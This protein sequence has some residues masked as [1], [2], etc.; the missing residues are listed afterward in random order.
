MIE[1]F[2]VCSRVDQE[3]ARPVHSAPVGQ[4]QEE[5]DAK[6]SRIDR[7][8][9]LPKVPRLLIL[10]ILLILCRRHPAQVKNDW[11]CL[12]GQV[13]R[14][15]CRRQVVLGRVL[16]HCHSEVFQALAMPNRYSSHRCK[17]YADG[18]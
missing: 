15:L 1:Y 2:L 7:D 6:N 3:I 18:K 13:V 8:Q 5:A 12:V 11:H 17:E 14:I 9:P 4:K 10:T 16:L